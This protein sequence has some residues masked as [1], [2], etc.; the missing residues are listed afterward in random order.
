[1][2]DK[3]ITR[4]EVL[5]L[6]GAASALLLAACGGATEEPEPEP[7]AEDMEPVVEDDQA[8]DSLPADEDEGDGLL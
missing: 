2:T 3:N 6:G 8:S 1:M 5:A 4:R 7:E